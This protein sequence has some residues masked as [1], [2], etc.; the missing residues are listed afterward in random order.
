MAQ[1][2]ICFEPVHDFPR[3]NAIANFAFLSETLLWAIRL[4]SSGVFPVFAW[5]LSK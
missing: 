4:K 3:L 5:M 2:E 1:I